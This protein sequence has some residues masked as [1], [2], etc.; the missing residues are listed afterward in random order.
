MTDTP[1]SPPDK[2]QRE[3]VLRIA[4]GIP[5][6]AALLSLI[7]FAPWQGVAIIVLLACLLGMVEYQRLMAKINGYHMLTVH[8]IG[9]FLICG[10]AYLAGVAGLQAMLGVAVLVEFVWLLPRGNDDARMRAIANGVFGL[11]WIPWSFGHLILILQRPDGS[12]LLLFLVLV[13]T[14]NDSL[15]YFTG[16]FLGRHKLMP[17]V[18]PNKTIEGSLG[19]IVGGVIGGWVAVIWLLPPHFG[20][21]L[22]A[23]LGMSILLA[24]VGQVGDLVESMLK[25]A[26]GVKDSGRFLPGH[27][28]FLDRLDVFLL[29]PPFMYYY[30]WFVL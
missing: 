30:L 19:G 18:S 29:T 5:A 16:K 7:A 3:L 11:V 23:M 1:T 10:G 8:L 27:G 20:W 28:G 22:P 21:E 25:R 14:F 4:S 2:K 12:R 24:V 9:V 13:L 26:A 17:G 6:L 15:A